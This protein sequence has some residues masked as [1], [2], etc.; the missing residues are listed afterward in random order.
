MILVQGVVQ[1]AG[2][3]GEASADIGSGQECPAPRL[4]VSHDRLV[5]QV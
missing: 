5:Q 2:A 1:G 3:Q 4:D